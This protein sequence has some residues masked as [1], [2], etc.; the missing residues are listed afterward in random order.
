VNTRVQGKFCCREIFGPV[1]LMLVT[2]EMEVL[3]SFL[4]LA[5]NFA[6][7]FRVVGNSEAGSNT[8]TFVKSTHESGCKLGAVIREDFLWDSIKAE[9]IPIVKISSVFGR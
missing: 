2:E 4:V 8:E 3:L 6:I 9:D 1:F 7:T 5:L